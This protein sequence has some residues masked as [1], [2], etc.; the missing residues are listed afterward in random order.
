MPLRAQSRLGKYRIVRRLGEGGFA[1][2]FEAY[3]TIEG[4]RVALKIP[5]A[6]YV[7]NELLESFKREIRLV[8]KLDHPNIL[9]VK[10]ADFI[11]DKFVI[12]MPLADRTLADRL[13]NRLSVASALSYF[14][15]MAEGLACAHEQRIIHCDIKPDNMLLFSG[16]HLMLTDFGLAKVAFHT[17]RGSGS[18]TVGYI[19]P[20]QAMGHPSLRSDVFSLGLVAYRMLSGH[21][22][23]WPFSWPPEGYARLQKKAHPQLIDLLRRSIEFEPRSRY[24]DAG[25]L[26]SAFNRVKSR[27][28]R[29][30]RPQQQVG[31]RS[32]NRLTHWKSIQRRQ[33]MRQFGSQLQTRFACDNCEG[34][35]SEV[36]QHCPWCGKQR[37][38]HNGVTNFPQICPRCCRGMKL[39]WRF[40]P[41]EQGSEFERSSNRN[42][43]DR[44][45]V[46]RCANPA[47]DRKLLMPFMRF[48]PW[49]NAEVVRKWQIKASKTSCKACGW[50]I[51]GD[52]WSWCA[53]CGED[54]R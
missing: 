34:P 40:C 52:F 33:F 47:C 27:A 16:D 41:W 42:F 21:L 13:Q 5:S 1:T 12:A 6:R 36:M 39:D 19:A 29:F 53:W 4:V 49:C 35:V 32:S 22:P 24:R 15:Q 48:C 46:G 8:S 45:Y 7:D 28:L 43:S 50:G 44:R 2:V 20:E 14:E 51:A 26:L 54:L 38:Q 37:K 9:P 11:D 25:Q 23:Q 31:T 30:G 18:G 3:D 17:L 10:N